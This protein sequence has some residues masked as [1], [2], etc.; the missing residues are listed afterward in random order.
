MFRERYWKGLKTVQRRKYGNRPQEY[1]GISYHSKKEADY[2]ARLD[3]EKR[4]GEIKSWE[5]QFKIDLRVNGYHITNYYCD[6]LVH[7]N[8]G[9]KELI[10][11]KGRFLLNNPVFVL[12]R[13]LVEAVFLNEN[14]DFSYT[15][16]T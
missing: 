16:V 12:K 3:L 10:E 8:D 11:V 7:H 15:I 4:A 1:N 9:R 5:R 14:K 13:K 6:F 2:A